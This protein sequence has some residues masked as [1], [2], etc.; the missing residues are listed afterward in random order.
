[1][2][3]KTLVKVTI[4]I[5]I[6]HS[7]NTELLPTFLAICLAISVEVGS[8]FKQLVSINCVATLRQSL[9]KV[10]RHSTSCNASG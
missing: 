2:T 6:R 4:M 1:M 5:N 7:E 8:I 10:E 3:N 9:R